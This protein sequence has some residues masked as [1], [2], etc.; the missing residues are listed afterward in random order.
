MNQTVIEY[1][2]IIVTG[3]ENLLPS[4]FICSC[5]YFVMRFCEFSDEED[6]NKANRERYG[7]IEKVLVR[8]DFLFG[9]SSLWQ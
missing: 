1:I 8:S 7:Q 5:I 3:C 2:S 9:G 4:F 6:M